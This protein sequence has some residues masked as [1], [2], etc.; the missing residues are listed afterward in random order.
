MKVN[1]LIHRTPVPVLAAWA[2]LCSVH[3]ASGRADRASA[4]PDQT[5]GD[6]PCALGGIVTDMRSGAALKRARVQLSTAGSEAEGYQAVQRRQLGIPGAAPSQYSV[7]S[8]E[9]GRFCFENVRAGEYVLSGRRRGYLDTNYG[10]MATTETGATLEVPVQQDASIVLALIP[11]SIIS[12]RVTDADGE[13]IDSGTVEVIS[14]TWIRGAFRNVPVRGAQPNDLGEFRV[15]GLPAGTYYVVFQPVA[16][17][18]P[19]RESASG[20]NRIR[21]ARTFFP[22]AVR[23]T[24]AAAVRVG[25]GEEIPDINLQA[26]RLPTYRVRGTIMGD[27]D[28]ADMAVMSLSPADEESTALVAGGGNAAQQNAFD[29]PDLAPGVYRLTYLSSSHQVANTVRALL[30]VRDRDIDEARIDA[31]APVSI[32]GRVRV[33]GTGTPD[34]SNIEVRLSSI[35]ALV[36]PT[37][38]GKTKSDG[39]FVIDNISAGKYVVSANVPAGKYLKSARYGQTDLAGREFEVG[40]GAGEM[41]IVLR[42]GAAQVEG[43]IEPSP[44]AAGGEEHRIPGR[45]YYLLVPD[46]L[47]ADGSGLR[48][49]RAGRDG[50]FS[51]KDLTPGHYRA[52]ASASLDLAAIQN[53]SV[54]KAMEA[55]GT[56]L[57]LNENDK[58][59]LSLHVVS[60]EQAAWAFAFSR[61]Q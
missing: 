54:L 24:Q 16:G 56:G 23:I 1:E 9:N 43:A 41:E 6:R 48:F 37:F 47:G 5:A 50:R 32:H 39:T 60:A 45:A 36:A 58:A 61:T 46:K 27:F 2:I 21:L 59:A 10:A 14:R 40:A 7:T 51:V 29:F 26:Q 17:D 8:D 13:P 28:H 52:Y 19:N 44:D 49:G 4:A 25:A 11:Q 20:G 35:E 30:E 18:D 3:A 34:L 42:A 15:A 38:S 31:A 22:S 33:D 57:Q 53:P 12:G 55:F